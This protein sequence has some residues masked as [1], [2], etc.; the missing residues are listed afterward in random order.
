MQGEYPANGDVRLRFVCDEG[1]TEPASGRLF[2]CAKCRE[3][4]VVCSR[5]DRGQIYC[6]GDCSG[7]ARRQSLR[8]AAH[9]YRQ[10][11]RGRK[12]G[13]ARTDRF[14]ARKRIVT[15]QGSP[16]QPPDDL[17]PAGATVT[18][19]DISPAERP[20][21]LALHCHWCGRPCLPGLR[22]DFL[23]RRDHRRGRIGHARTE[24]N[25]PW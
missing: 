9:R 23:R 20:Q 22:Q 7:V 6:S 10:T 24:R 14:R 11:S 25:A 15:H 19:N 13:A 16:P 3:Q 4:V 21:R 8:E 5:C 12:T 1:Q 2:L 18:T 17:L